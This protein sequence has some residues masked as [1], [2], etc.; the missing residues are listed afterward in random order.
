MDQP[1]TIHEKERLFSTLDSQSLTL[2]ELKRGMYGDDKNKVPGVLK[3]VAD[4][5]DWISNSKKKIT[6]ISGFAAGIGFLLA[7]AWEW[8]VNH[9]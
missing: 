1:L 6:F 3:D 9:K 7:K 2:E 8:V 5:K 4:I